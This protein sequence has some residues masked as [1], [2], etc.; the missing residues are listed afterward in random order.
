MK[1]TFAKKLKTIS[2]VRCGCSGYRKSALTTVS[3][4][5]FIT[6]GLHYYT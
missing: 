6:A 2:G 3:A 5:E 1:F 4:A